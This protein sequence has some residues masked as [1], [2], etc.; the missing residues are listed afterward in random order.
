VT[1]DPNF[2]FYRDNRAA[3]RAPPVEFWDAMR[4]EVGDE[5]ARRRSTY[6]GLIAKGRMSRADA[7]REL[8]VWQ[9][10]AEDWR[11]APRSAGYPIATWTE[12]VHALRREIALRRKFYPQWVE[13]RRLDV[14]E[15]ERK[16]MLVERWHDLLWHGRGADA[17]AA[18]VERDRLLEQEHR[19]AA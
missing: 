15:A 4:V 7:D 3:D 10:I 19:Q 18:R 9:A 14:D 13:A 11:A 17:A 8:R 2:R 12:M 1:F 6:P 5:L 16:L